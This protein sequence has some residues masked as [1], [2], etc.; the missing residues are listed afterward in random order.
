MTTGPNTS[1]WTISLS[2]AGPT[3]IDGRVE[4][5]AAVGDAAL[6]EHLGAG[7]LGPRDHPADALQLLGRDDRP[8]LGVGVGGVAEG[9][10]AHLGLEGGDDVVVHLGTG[11]HPAGRRAVLP[12]L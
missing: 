7:L 5:A 6:G 10:L 3:T 11:D 1:R 2:W 4:V 9:D 8:D 12:E